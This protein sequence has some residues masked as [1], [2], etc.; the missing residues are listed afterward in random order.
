MDAKV[1]F[2]QEKRNFA[3]QETKTAHFHDRSSSTYRSRHHCVRDCLYCHDAGAECQCE[4]DH[5]YQH[6]V[7]GEFMWKCFGFLQVTE[8]QEETQYSQK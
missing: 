4:E 3:D 5:L 1:V 7:G 6:E 8:T 2:R